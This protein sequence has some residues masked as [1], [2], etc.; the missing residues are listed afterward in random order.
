MNY[1]RNFIVNIVTAI[2]FIIIGVFTKN[3][4]AF[5]IA[6][7]FLSAPFVLYWVSKD[8]DHHQIDLKEKELEDIKEAAYRTWKYFEDNLTEEYNYLIP[9]NYQENREEKLDHRTSPTAI[10][11]SLTAVVSA[12]ELEFIDREKAVFL[13][14]KILK[15]I[16]EL[17]KWHGHLYNWYDIKTMTVINPQ[18]V[19]T[20]DSGNLVA[21][22]IVAREFLNSL[23]EIEL[24]KLCDKLIKNTNFKKLYTKRN[25]FS[26]GYDEGEGKLSGY[27]YNK[28]A[29]ES[30]LT[31]YLAICL[32]D[33]PS[34]HWFSLDKSLTTYK[35][36]KGL[37][38]WSVKK[39]ILPKY[40]V[41]YLG[42][43]QSLPTMN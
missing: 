16:D 35:G 36:H 29:S 19:S 9:D 33:A 42:V 34:K 28:F 32:G 26:I 38:S 25:V 2:L 39:T 17:S 30:R 1:I 40:L 8:I 13:L 4:L 21:S 5:V 7:V 23:D 12:Y 15:A 43:F 41:N 3:V 10:G 31:S 22:Y 6:F 37:I 18:F 11:F 24:V 14:E 27:N 20:V